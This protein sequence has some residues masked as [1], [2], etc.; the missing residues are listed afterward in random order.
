L[1]LVPIRAGRD[2]CPAVRVTDT[3]MTALTAAA[4]KI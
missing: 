2:V 4:A 1:G 3:E